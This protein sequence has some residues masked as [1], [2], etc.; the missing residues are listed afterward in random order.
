MSVNVSPDEDGTVAIP[1]GA[2][3]PPPPLPQAPTLTVNPKFNPDPDPTTGIL[4]VGRRCEPR[5]ES[6]TIPTWLNGEVEPF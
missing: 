5:G 2:I 6:A 3:P 4:L 1:I